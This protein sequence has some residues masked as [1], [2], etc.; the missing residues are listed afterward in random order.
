MRKLRFEYRF[1]NNEG[2]SYADALQPVNI[3]TGKGGEVLFSI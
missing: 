1:E 3:T 2:K